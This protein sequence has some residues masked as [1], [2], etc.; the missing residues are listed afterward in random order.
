MMK[1][2][3]DNRGLT[4][5]EVLVALGIFTMFIGTISVVFLYSK[6]SSTIVFDQLEAQGEARRALRDFTTEV[7]SATYS[8]VGSYPIE[9]ATSTSLV[10]F[11]N[12][13]TDSLRERVR[14]FVSTATLKRGV[15]KPTGTPLTYMTSTE[16]ITDV[17]RYVRNTSTPIFT[18]YNQNYTGTSTPLTL[19]INVSFINM[20][21]VQL[22]ID[23]S[24]S[25]SPATLK[26]EAQ[27]QIRNLKTN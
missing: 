6:R 10:F 16:Q 25:T 3:R 11:T 7:R 21:G 8:S 18:Y 20:I 24:P 26:V 19:P 9:S 4:L 15:T 22:V 14:Y 5:V 23:K 27:A 17:V 2:S 1:R 12:L 13:D